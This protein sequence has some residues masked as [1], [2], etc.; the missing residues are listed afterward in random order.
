MNKPYKNN[1]IIDISIFQVGL[2]DFFSSTGPYLRANL[3]KKIIKCKNKKIMF[4]T[5][6]SFIQTGRF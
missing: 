1:N 5:F 6:S 2:N 4:L 3:S